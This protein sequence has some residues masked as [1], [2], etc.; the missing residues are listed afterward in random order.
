[1]KVVPVTLVCCMPRSSCSFARLLLQRHGFISGPQSATR[2]N[3][4]P[5]V[6]YL[7]ALKSESSKFEFIFLT[8]TLFTPAPSSI[9][10]ARDLLSG[11]NRVSVGRGCTAPMQLADP[12]NLPYLSPQQP[13]MHAGFLTSGRGSLTN[14]L[15]FGIL[16]ALSVLA[17]S[18]ASA[19]SR[20]FK[21][22]T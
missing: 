9:A 12:A 7:I 10:A 1:M 15:R 13:V 16:I 18:V 19:G 6:E 11:L 22:R 21:W 5:T 8:S 17:S 4:A 14:M 3:F 2:N 20:L